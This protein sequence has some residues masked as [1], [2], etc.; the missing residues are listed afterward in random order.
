MRAPKI[1]L[2]LHS[3]PGRPDLADELAARGLEVRL[4]NNMASTWAQAREWGPDAVLLAS[5][6][7]DPAGP[8]LGSL[9]RLA[10]DPGGPALLVMTDAPETLLGP[11]L[12]HD[13]AVEVDDFV[14]TDLH[15][16]AIARRVRIAVTRNEA[17]GRLNAERD[18]LL[19]KT[20]TD[21][22]TGLFNDRHFKQRSHQEM[23]RAQRQEHPLGVI[24][25][26]FD[27]FKRINDDCD[28][29]FGDHTLRT[30]ARALQGGL[31]EF[32]VPARLGGDEFAVLLPN[33]KL[34]DAVT[35]AE[36]LQRSVRELEIRDRDHSA[37]LT[38]SMGVA[39]W[40]P[41]G[42][43]SF[44]ATQQGADHA[45]LEAKRLGRDGICVFDGIVR[46]Q[47]PKAEAKTE[48]KKGEA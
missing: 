36:R 14:P 42:E 6:S 18:D 10:R 23:S 4:S 47:V 17:I 19:Q 8:E 37:R 7:D 20:I 9:L 33:T 45:L 3:S 43:R 31:R 44:E 35:I 40:S 11:E 13:L 39:S 28:H 24:M 1:L 12:T 5:L 2:A 25:I 21:F 46:Q 48:K 15:A 30:F 38:V 34:A 16:K 26:D 32:D 41:T 22:K 27:D 29:A